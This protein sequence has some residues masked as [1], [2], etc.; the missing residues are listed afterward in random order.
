MSVISADAGATRKRVEEL[1]KEAGA[2]AADDKQIVDR[3]LSSIALLSQ[4][5]FKTDGG[6]LLAL[7]APKQPS[8]IQIAVI[9]RLLPMPDPVVAKALVQ[10][11]RWSSYTQPVKDAVLNGVLSQ[12][13]LTDALL[14]AIET[15]G[16][17]PLSVNPEK[18]NQLMKNKDPE[19]A[20]RA[21]A[22]FSNLVPGDRMKVYEELK[23]VLELKRVAANGHKIFTQTCAPCHVISG[24]G[25]AVGPDL[26]GIRNQPA[27]V[28][29]LHILVP[30]FEIMPIYT[31]YTVETKDG[32][33]LSGVLASENSATVT[34]RQALGIDENI[35]RSNIESM[36][37][38]SLSLMPQELEKAMSKQ[39][40]ADL[41]GF[42][43]G[44]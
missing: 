1:I 9:R 27:D 2:I 17:S 11:E 42:L 20:K 43:K 25:H 39:D 36:T 10:R 13:A 19:I 37:S 41:I 8:E 3:R 28:L 21:T 30:E 29:L 26:T 34:I 14:S 6:A 44:E 38:S 15:G 12:P 16:I 33:T 35:P 4:G 7:V 31:Q 40:L 24:E 32:R 23:A 22:L 5:D 18:R